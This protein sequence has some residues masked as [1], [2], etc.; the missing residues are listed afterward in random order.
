MQNFFY[1]IIFLIGTG[2]IVKRAPYPQEDEK[3]GLMDTVRGKYLYQIN[4]IFK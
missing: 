2:E 4:S 3:P 1:G